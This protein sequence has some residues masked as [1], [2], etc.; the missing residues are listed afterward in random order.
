MVKYEFTMKER[1][2]RTQVMVDEV[3]DGNKKAR[4]D[5]CGAGGCGCGCGAGYQ[6]PAAA[7]AWRR[8]AS[9]SGR[10]SARHL[11]YASSVPQTQSQNCSAAFLGGGTQGTGEVKRR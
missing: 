5:T 7:A 10:F 8:A 1:K 9:R 11:L 2:T 6:F 3:D 4:G